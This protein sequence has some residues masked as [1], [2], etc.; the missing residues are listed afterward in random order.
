[1]SRGSTM[2]ATAIAV[3]EAPTAMAAAGATA[4][5]AAPTASARALVAVVRLM[6]HAA[7]G[8]QHQCSTG[9]LGACLL[10]LVATVLM[11]S[12][13]A[14]ALA[15]VTACVVLRVQRRMTARWCRMTRRCISTQMLIQG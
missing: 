10:L 14:T 6:A 3:A 8:A 4:M 1:M 7:G 9:E 12:A 11:M 2:V 13:V 15:A 5:V